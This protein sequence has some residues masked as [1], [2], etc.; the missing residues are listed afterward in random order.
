MVNECTSEHAASF[1]N[2]T[3]LASFH[4]PFL[5]IS[6]VILTAHTPGG[7]V[8]VEPKLEVPEIGLFPTNE[9]R[10]VCTVRF[11]VGDLC[12]CLFASFSVVIVVLKICNWRDLDGVAVRRGRRISSNLFGDRTPFFRRMT[13][14]CTNFARTSGLRLA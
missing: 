13:R 11:S 5:H 10:R 1:I 8:L 12:F 14:H 2:S 9:N 3:L 7:V 4:I 6:E